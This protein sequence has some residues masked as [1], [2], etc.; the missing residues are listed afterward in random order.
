[1]IDRMLMEFRRGPGKHEQIVSVTGRHLGRSVGV[2]SLDGNHIDSYLR[3]VLF[4]PL[5]DEFGAEPGV[6]F[7]DQMSPFCDPQ[8]F[9]IA[10]STGG[11]AKKRTGRGD[12]RGQFDEIPA[13]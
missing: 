4:S 5:L 13:R 2:N 1:M 8:R 11:E 9:C 12:S 7:G 10:E 6:I 3:V